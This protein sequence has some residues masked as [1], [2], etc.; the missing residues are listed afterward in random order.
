LSA[1]LLRRLVG[2]LGLAPSLVGTSPDG[3]FQ[4]VFL[5]VIPAGAGIH[6]QQQ[7][8][9]PARWHRCLSGILAR[10]ADEDAG[11]AGAVCFVYAEEVAVDADFVSLLGHPAYV[12]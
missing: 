11:D 7:A 9:A 10:F 12:A 6:E 1:R 3:D 8:W 5:C 2:T 4:V